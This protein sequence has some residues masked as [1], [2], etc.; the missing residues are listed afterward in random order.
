M[1]RYAKIVDEETKEVQV[2]VGCDEEFYKE[3]GMTIMDVE[4]AYTGD[5]YVKGY[6]PLPPEPTTEEKQAEVRGVR[7]SYLQSTDFTQ[8]DDAPFTEDEK[9]EYREYRQY[10]RDYTNGQ[11]W[12]E[13]NPKTFNEWKEDK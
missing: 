12:W 5:W 10:L 11:N 4:Q 8:L 3:I 6:A 9:I 7:D 1:E 2:G 13:Q